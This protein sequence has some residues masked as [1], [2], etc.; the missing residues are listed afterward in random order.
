MGDHIE[1][2]CYATSQILKVMHCALHLRIRKHVEE[3][4]GCG[5]IQEFCYRSKC[6]MLGGTEQND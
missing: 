5:V 1:K 3:T 6:L 4:N 2:R